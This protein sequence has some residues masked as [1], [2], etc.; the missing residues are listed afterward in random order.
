MSS[1]ISLTN[2]PIQIKQIHV[3]KL[4][5][6]DEPKLHCFSKCGLLK[7]AS[8]LAI[9]PKLLKIYISATPAPSQNSLNPKILFRILQFYTNFA[10]GGHIPLTVS[11]LLRHNVATHRLRQLSVVQAVKVLALR[12]AVDN[13]S[14]LWLHPTFRDDLELSVSLRCLHLLHV[15]LR[16]T[17]STQY[18][19][20]IYFFN[21]RFIHYF[22]FHAC[23]HPGIYFIHYF[24]IFYF[25]VHNMDFYVW[26][27]TSLC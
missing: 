12:T 3:W 20:T 16:C 21:D 27:K 14:T 23:L 5:T 2:N 9:N 10:V 18:L 7:F 6:T 17:E 13:D 24:F 1:L 22:L 26:N 11:G 15:V 25:H 8:N 19:V 4:W